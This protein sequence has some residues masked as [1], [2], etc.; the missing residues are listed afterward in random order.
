M[1]KI[2]TLYP[3]N[4]IQ[5]LPKWS[6]NDRNSMVVWLCQGPNPA[7]SR[8]RRDM[9]SWF[10]HL[11]EGCAKRD[12][13]Q[14]LRDTSLDGACFYGALYELVFHEYFLQKGWNPVFQPK[15]NGKTPDLLIHPPGIGKAVCC[16]V[17]SIHDIVDLRDGERSRKELDRAI[18]KQVGE[19][20]DVE[21]DYHDF[22][23]SDHLAIL[24]QVRRWAEGLDK[25]GGVQ[26]LT[27]NEPGFRAEVRAVWRDP[28]NRKAVD[29]KLS[30]GPI[31]ACDWQ[32]GRLR[33]RVESKA[34]KYVGCGD[35]LV[36]A[37]GDKMSYAGIDR[38]GVYAALYGTT[39][40]A[41]SPSQPGKP[42]E[43]EPSWVPDGFFMDFDNS[44]GRFKRTHV[45][46][47]L[48]ARCQI[49]AQGVVVPL[50]V[51]H[52]PTAKVRLPHALFNDV[53]QSDVVR[54]T[55]G[56]PVPKCIGKD[57]GPVKLTPA[58]N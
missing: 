47:V 25:A 50:E 57:L 6:A 36:V 21:I 20:F 26:V 23:P 48:V 55:G 17:V 38:D 30:F 3:N 56:L 18:R 15:V 34:K 58:G 49:A 12:L 16:E 39:T 32:I 54:G 11:P 41:L 19:D 9:E 22:P 52:N 42:V 13:G 28:A 35:S 5:N 33:D 10:V 51:Y 31:I 53:P 24:E 7:A 27:I 8:M 45:S 1:E 46:A 14:R 4:F 37:V 2:G 29:P 40:Y 44:A 43:L